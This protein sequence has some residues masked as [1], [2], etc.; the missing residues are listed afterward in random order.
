MTAIGICFEMSEQ[1]LSLRMT[2]VEIAMIEQ[3]RA[4]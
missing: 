4:A 2:A 3:W 1:G